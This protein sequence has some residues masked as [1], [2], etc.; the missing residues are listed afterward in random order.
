MSSFSASHH[1]DVHC[2]KRSSV[3]LQEAIQLKAETTPSVSL[4]SN[5]SLQAHRSPLMSCKH[6]R[7]LF[8]QVHKPALCKSQYAGQ[9]ANAAVEII[10]APL[11]RTIN[12]TQRTSSHGGSQRGLTPSLRSVLSY[13]QAPSLQTPSRVGHYVSSWCARPAT[14]SCRRARSGCYAPRQHR[15]ARPIRGK[16]PQTPVCK[17]APSAR[18]AQPGKH[19]F[20]A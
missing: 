18:C 15:P 2:I 3:R 14:R 20:G 4:S 10:K 11:E 5:L 12:W 16:L 1:S 9:A 7:H 8:Q 6:I 13:M 17:P 19:S